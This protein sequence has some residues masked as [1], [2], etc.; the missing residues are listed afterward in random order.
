MV[1]DWVGC[2]LAEV[3]SDRV[4]QFFGVV[5]EGAFGGVLRDGFDLEPVCGF[6]RD[7]VGRGEERGFGFGVDEGLIGLMGE[8]DVAA[9]AFR[10]AASLGAVGGETL[11]GVYAVAGGAEGLLDDGV[12]AEFIE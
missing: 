6:K 11:F 4:E 9:L 5:R 2:K 1:N 3:F 8:D 12:E 7:G 10:L